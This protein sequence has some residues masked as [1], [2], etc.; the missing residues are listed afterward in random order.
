MKKKPTTRKPSERRAGLV[1]NAATKAAIRHD[2][3][4]PPV[5]AAELRQFKPVALS[6]RIR[7]KLEMSQDAFSRAY[8]IP[9][10]TLRD[11][12]QHRS[13]PDQAAVTLL[14]LIE[15]DPKGVLKRL[16]KVPA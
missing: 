5:S 12:E 16:E 14:Q 11:W 9:L 4:N 13:E 15:V 8:R 10:G 6:K 7:W 1:P 3:E 2:P